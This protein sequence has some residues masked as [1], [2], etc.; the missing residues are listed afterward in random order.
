MSTWN[1]FFKTLIKILEKKKYLPH[2]FLDYIWDKI[3][4]SVFSSSTSLPLTK[5]TKIL[6]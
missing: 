2:F 1:V 4:N 3:V 5:A 6:K